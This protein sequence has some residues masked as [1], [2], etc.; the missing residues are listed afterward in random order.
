M[1]ANPQRYLVLF[2]ALQAF[3]SLT[4]DISLP[5][6]PQ[7]AEDLVATDAQTQLTVSIFMAGMCL[8]MLIFGPLSDKYGRR[9]LLLGG[10]AV[11]I[12]ATVGCWFAPTVDSLV[13]W[14]FLQA[15]G[16]AAAAILTRAIARDSFAGEDIPRILSL[17]QV[18]SM[19]AVAAAPMLGTIIM[20]LGSWRWIF[21]AL[22]LF[23]LVTGI[24]TFLKIPE[25]LPQGQRQDS[26]FKTFVAYWHILMCLPAVGYI[27]AMTFTF[28]AMFVYIVV[29]PFVFMEYFGLSEYQFS[30][31]FAA[32]TFG[33]LLFSSFNA[34]FVKR[35]GS[36]LIIKLGVFCGLISAAL[37]FAAWSVFDSSLLM[38]LVALFLVISCVGLMGANCTSN[39]MALF[40]SNA[41]AAAGLAVATQF[42]LGAGIA[43]IAS[44]F[45]DGT[46]QAMISVIGACCVG[47]GLAYLLARIK[48]NLPH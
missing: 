31:I 26:V 23:G 32:N 22:A 2:A 16:G 1:L 34:R 8:G 11:Y 27:L 5:A 46:P 21:A 17:M 43:M 45:H 7:I 38:I 33:I 42:G 29:S 13:A 3:A 41:G 24:L 14:R 15:F 36:Q 18:V 10:I 47:M 20:E 39:L 37:L 35:L 12:I 30:M 6:L 48:P 4:V 40:P 28:S 44:S 19:I 25:T 9:Q